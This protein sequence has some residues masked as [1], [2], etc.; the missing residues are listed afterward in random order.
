[1]MARHWQVALS[2]AFCMTTIVL[3]AKTRAHVHLPARLAA[4]RAAAARKWGGGDRVPAPE[5]RGRRPRARATAL[6]HTSART[7]L[8]TRFEPASGPGAAKCEPRRRRGAHARCELSSRPAG[9][10]EAG[11]RCAARVSTLARAKLV[12]RARRRTPTG[13][14]GSLRVES[15]LSGARQQVTQGTRHR[16]AAHP[17]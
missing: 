6:L 16:R 9:E 17:A 4:R 3:V 7:P 14:A 10:R 12:A 8:S 13:C 2:A 15:G 1:M 11:K 5:K